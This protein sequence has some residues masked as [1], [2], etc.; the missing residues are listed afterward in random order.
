MILITG[1]IV[2]RPENRER[3]LALGAEHS[4]RSRKEPGCIAHNC[5]SDAEDPNRV[6]FVEEWTDMAAVKAHFAVPASS[7]FVRQ[8]GEMADEAPVMRMFEA[9]ELKS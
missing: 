9:S 6:A 1:H 2:V 7:Q 4:A 3:A 8:I 5:H